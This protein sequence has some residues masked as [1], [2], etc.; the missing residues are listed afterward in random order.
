MYVLESVSA[1]PQG[2]YVDK[3]K[4]YDATT[5]KWAIDGTVLTYRAKLYFIWSG[6]P[7]DKGDFP[8]NLYIAP[9]SNPWTI[10]GP[11][12]LLSEPT[13]L[14]E[15]SGAAIN[16]GP[17]VLTRQE[18]IFIIYSANASWKPDYGLG[19]LS[20]VG[21]DPL[22]AK[23][24]LKHPEPVFEQADTGIY[25]PGHASFI[26]SPDGKEDWIIYHAKKNASDNWEREIR[27]QQFSWHN[28]GTPNFGKPVPDGITLEVPSGEYHNS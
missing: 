5:D 17:Q 14:W 4:I 11:R 23:N 28:D 12:V 9:M 3:G 26:K 1:D 6:W 7:G 2:G 15:T 8:Q 24:W 10:S 22:T 25:G 19:Q 27:T 20:L 13:Y 18:R 16:E 21:S